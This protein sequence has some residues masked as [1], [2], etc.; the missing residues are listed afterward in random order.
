MSHS[1]NA[2]STDSEDS[3]LLHT[4]LALKDQVC[5]PNLRLAAA[6]MSLCRLLTACRGALDHLFHTGG[7]FNF[8]L[9]AD[10]S[11][12]YSWRMS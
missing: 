8:N 3:S 9:L 12:L 5:A 11:K 6:M 2:C 1:D 7:P 4:K 10:P